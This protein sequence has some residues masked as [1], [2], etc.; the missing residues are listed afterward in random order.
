MANLAREMMEMLRSAMCCVGT[1]A[2]PDLQGT[3]RLIRLARVAP[4]GEGEYHAAAVVGG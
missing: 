1:A 4:G 2:I 3:P